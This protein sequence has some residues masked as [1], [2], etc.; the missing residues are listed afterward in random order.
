MLQGNIDLSFAN[1]RSYVRHLEVDAVTGGK[2]GEA[3]KLPVE[4][5]GLDL[6]QHS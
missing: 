1:Y 2:R 4:K 5:D 6:G 3:A